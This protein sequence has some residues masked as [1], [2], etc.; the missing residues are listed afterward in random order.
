MIFRGN[1]E[2]QLLYPRSPVTKENID[3]SVVF[4]S[5]DIFIQVFLLP[6]SRSLTDSYGS[7]ANLFWY[8]IDKIALSPRQQTVSLFSIYKIVAQITMHM[9]LVN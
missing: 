4:T 2:F 1:A 6:R 9:R 5:T 3:K 8:K 7:Y